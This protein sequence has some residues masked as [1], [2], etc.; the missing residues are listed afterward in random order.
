[1]GDKKKLPLGYC[2]MVNKAYIKCVGGMLN[3]K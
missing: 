1:M 2:N 3:G